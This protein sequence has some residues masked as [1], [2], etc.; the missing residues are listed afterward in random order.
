MIDMYLLHSLTDE[1]HH[2]KYAEIG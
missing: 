1:V 2:I